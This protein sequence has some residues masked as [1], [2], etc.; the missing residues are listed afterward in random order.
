M[1]SRQHV[2]SCVLSPLQSP[3]SSL[4]R[5]SSSPWWNRSC[6][7]LS[8]IWSK[9][10]AWRPVYVNMATFTSH[11]EVAQIQSFCPQMTRI[12]L[13]CHRG[14]NSPRQ[15]FKI[16][17]RPLSYVLDHPS[18]SDITIRMV[19]L[20]FV[21]PFLAYH[22]SM[23]IASVS[24]SYSPERRHEV[25]QKCQICFCTLMETFV[26]AKLEGISVTQQFLR[27]LC[28]L[29]LAFMMLLLLHILLYICGSCF[30]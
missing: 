25:C 19:R 4:W 1:L 3:S 5:T 17:F 11:A 7:L 28:Y 24:A 20:K 12:K 6:L 8:M 21:C 23:H 26:Q 16:K 30:S 10:S 22:F 15:I 13:F 18:V 2:N 27:K 14:V 29:I 9:S